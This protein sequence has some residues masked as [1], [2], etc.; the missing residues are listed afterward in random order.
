MPMLSIERRDLPSQPILFVRSR[1][2]RADIAKTI[3]ESLGKVFPY[4]IGS[5]AAI[6][7]QPFARYP[8]VGHGLMTID[9]GV[10]LATAA[11]GQGDIQAGTLQEG[12]AVMAVHG[13]AYDQLME[14][15]GAIELW[16]GEHGL[17]PGG[18][19]WEVYTTD[20]ADHPDPADWRTEI[21]WPV[22][23]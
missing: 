7:G 2:A 13:G 23:G 20:P 3:A 6:A 4:A 22:K 17:A 16:M 19:P 15:Y 14:T 8:E 18:P 12:P 11:P 21:C 1:I 5:G 9:V 10:R